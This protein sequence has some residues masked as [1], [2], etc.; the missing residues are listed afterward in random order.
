M[1][2]YPHEF[3]RVS[4][5]VDGPIPGFVIRLHGPAPTEDPW[6][7]DVAWGGSEDGRTQVRVEYEATPVRG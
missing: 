1:G 3:D 4:F 7:D 5:T 6:D 2:L